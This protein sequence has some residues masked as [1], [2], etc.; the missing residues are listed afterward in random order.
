MNMHGEKIKGIS[1]LGTTTTVCTIH[2]QICYRI[3]IMGMTYLKD[4]MHQMSVQEEGCC[5]TSRA[6]PL[7]LD[8]YPAALDLTPDKK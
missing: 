6:A 1:T 2:N 7:F 3:N 8:A 4:K 5:T